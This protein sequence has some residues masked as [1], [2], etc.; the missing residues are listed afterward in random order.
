MSRLVPITMQY[1][2]IGTTLVNSLNVI[3]TNLYYNGGKK[4]NSVKKYLGLL[5]IASL[6]TVVLTIS[7][8]E[9]SNAFNQGIVGRPSPAPDEVYYLRGDLTAPNNDKSFDGEVVGNYLITVNFDDV[10]ITAEFDRSSH[11]DV[12]LEGWLI[13][14]DNELY[15]SVGQFNKQSMLHFSQEHMEPQIYDL[16]IITEKSVS[17][18]DSRVLHTIV[19]GASV[20][21]KI[22]AKIINMGQ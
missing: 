9:E 20:P 7:Y 17:D 15:F 19:G 18:T 2:A 21:M 10:K 4:L 3:V 8:I 16:F 5:V 22:S 6:F 1:N 12:I 13:N 11:Q 14:F